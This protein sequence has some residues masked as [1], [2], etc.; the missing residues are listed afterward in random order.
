MC[1]Q[2]E[3]RD[4]GVE[5]DNSRVLPL[6]RKTKYNW[7]RKGR[8]W[9]PESERGRERQRESERQKNKPDGSKRENEEGVVERTSLFGLPAYV[10]PVKR[11]SV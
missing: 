3:Q 11:V 4:T 10:P 5:K 1:A 7:P 6:A 8:S 9:V 2:K